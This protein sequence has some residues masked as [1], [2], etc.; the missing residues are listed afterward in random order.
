MGSCVDKQK[1]NGRRDCVCTREMQKQ[2]AGKRRGGTNRGQ[3]VAS[4]QEKGSHTVK[5]R[6]TAPD[7]KDEGLL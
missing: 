2:E 6:D 7:G 4:E 1:G 5:E 3:E